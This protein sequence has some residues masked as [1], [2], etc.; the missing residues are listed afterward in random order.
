MS[1]A[2]KLVLL[3]IIFTGIGTPF[4][5]VSQ[6]LGINASEV[7]IVNGLV[8]TFICFL[9][10]KFL[11]YQSSGVGGA[12]LFVIFGTLLVLNIGF[13]LVNHSLSLG[14]GLVSVIYA[15][16]PAATMITLFISLV[17]LREMEKVIVLRLIAGS[18]F[19]LIGTIL[20]SLSI[21]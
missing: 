3:A 13:I 18:L 9:C 16:T 1:P 17:F 21:K 14:G 12:G 11:N 4:L 8:S 6:R 15:I 19:I 20:V 2:V 7:L 10:F 5:K